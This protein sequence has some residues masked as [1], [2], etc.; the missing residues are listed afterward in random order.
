MIGKSDMYRIFRLFFISSILLLPTISYA[1]TFDKDVLNTYTKLSPRFLLMSSLKS[2]IKNSIDICLVYDE[3]DE[4]VADDFVIR[5]K[6]NYP[7]GIKNYP[8][9]IHKVSKD[10]NS[11]SSSQLLFLLSANLKFLQ[12]TIEYSKKNK[13]IVISY[14]ST[15][16]EKDA[17][18]SLFLGRRIVP[19]LNMKSMIDKD[20]QLDNLLLRISK[21]YVKDKGQN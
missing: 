19:Y 18:I 10:L 6:E 15:L 8:V 7:N 20:I 2:S 14:D 17:D 3:M 13:I 16:L 4:K 11:C 1:F 5:T 21:I 9:K 12:E